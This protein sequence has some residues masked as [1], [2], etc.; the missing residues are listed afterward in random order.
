MCGGSAAILHALPSLLKAGRATQLM[1]PSPRASLCVFESS[2]AL[3]A[4]A[5]TL[6]APLRAATTHR[7]LLG[8]R[9]PSH[10]ALAHQAELTFVRECLAP[11]DGMSFATSA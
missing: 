4:A 7:R 1:L 6:L 10:A 9:V 8:S 11:Y 5:I 2:A 3:L